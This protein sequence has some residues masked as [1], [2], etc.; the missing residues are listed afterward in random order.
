MSQS[1]SAARCGKRNLPEGAANCAHTLAAR[2]SHSH[3]LLLLPGA[4]LPK[5]LAAGVSETSPLRWPAPHQHDS[6]APCGD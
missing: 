5:W 6:K 1:H 2:K 3:I 4:V